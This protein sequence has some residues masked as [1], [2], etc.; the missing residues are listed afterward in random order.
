MKE[1]TSPEQAEQKKERV[2][3]TAPQ[4]KKSGQVEKKKQHEA[5]SSFF[6]FGLL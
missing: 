4:A 2:K 6:F 5:S 1:Q 3:R